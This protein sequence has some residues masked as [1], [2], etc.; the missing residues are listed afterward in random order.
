MPNYKLTYFNIRGLGEGPRLI[1][2][3]AG[4]KF[5]D[6]RLPMDSTEYK[7]I[8]PFGQIPILEVDGQIIGQSAAIMRYLAHQY[9]LAGDTPLE[10]AQIDSITDAGKD[11][12]QSTKDWWGVKF[13]MQQGDADTLYKETV[14]PAREKFFTALEKFLDKSPSGWIVG[15]KSLLG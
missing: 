10:D 14:L 9:G 4:V 7:A 2:A 1:F 12:G 6:H 8:S 13:G 15:K 3:Q 11:F 5:E